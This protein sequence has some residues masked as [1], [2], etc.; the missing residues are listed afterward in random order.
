MDSQTN[1]KLLVQNKQELA[2][3]E[4][5]A[6][7]LTRKVVR[8]RWEYSHMFGIALALE[9]ITIFLV[10]SSMA[11][12]EGLLLIFGIALFVTGTIVI[13]ANSFSNAGRKLKETEDK[14]TQLKCEIIELEYS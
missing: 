10:M 11:H 5:L 8:R 4:N 14:I 9:G 13:L 12:L 2:L 6:K 1:K 3:L 7:A